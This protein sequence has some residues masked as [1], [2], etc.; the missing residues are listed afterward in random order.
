MGKPNYGACVVV[1]LEEVRCIIMRRLDMV[2][3]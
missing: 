3:Y 1:F 2:R